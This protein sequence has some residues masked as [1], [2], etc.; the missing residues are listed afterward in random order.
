MTIVLDVL[1]DSIIVNIVNLKVHIDFII[2]FENVRKTIINIIEMIN[3]IMKQKQHILVVYHSK[4][5]KN[6]MKLLVST[7]LSIKSYL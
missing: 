6:M 3:R 7:C 1:I 2:Y 4:I 5:Y